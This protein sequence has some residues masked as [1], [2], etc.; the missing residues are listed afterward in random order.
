MKDVFEVVS[1]VVKAGDVLL[2]ST[3]RHNDKQ[4]GMS[5]VP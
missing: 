1:I 5:S 4:F 2:R 3:D